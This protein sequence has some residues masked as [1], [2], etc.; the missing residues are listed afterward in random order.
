[1]TNKQYFKILIAAFSLMLI[2]S[3]AS[4]AQTG[5]VKSK[6]VKKQK[7]DYSNAADLQIAREINNQIRRI[8]ARKYG[9]TS[10]IRVAVKNKVVTLKGKILTQRAYREI[11][12]YV[13]KLKGVRNFKNELNTG[14]NIGDCNKPNK[15]CNGECINCLQTCN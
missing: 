13:K 10:H 9:K 11:T 7:I 3:G 4:L 2:F 8:K 1:M 6:S 14:C 5:S 15:M 12:N